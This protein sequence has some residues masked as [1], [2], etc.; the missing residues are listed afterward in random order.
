GLLLALWRRP[1][2]SVYHT[3]SL[4]RTGRQVLGQHLKCSDG[5]GV[6][7]RYVAVAVV[8]ALERGWVDPWRLPGDQP[9]SGRVNGLTQQWTPRG[10]L[11]IGGSSAWGDQHGSSRP[12]AKISIGIG[13]EAQGL[14]VRAGAEA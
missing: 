12:D 9:G 10:M 6:S 11:L 4:P 1:M 2:R 5:P 13:K 7:G 8:R 3:P 14:R